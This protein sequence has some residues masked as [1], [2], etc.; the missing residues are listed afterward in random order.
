MS[1]YKPVS[2]EENSNGLLIAA[3]SAA[4]VTLLPIAAH[5]VGLLAHLPDPPSSVFDSD[6][7]TDSKDAHPFGIPDSLLGL[8]SYGITL[9]LV[10]LARKD[11]RAKK[12]LALK[13]IADGSVAGFNVAKQ[14]VSFRSLCSWCTGTA[15]CT[16]AMA[17]AGRGLIR[18]EAS[19][20]SR[21]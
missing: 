1:C 2:H 19:E 12:L 13:L 10:L 6:R 8:G 14:V 5:Q 11:P 17:L 21:L 15:L 7:I 18:D 3:T 16:L 9:A 20:L 4:I